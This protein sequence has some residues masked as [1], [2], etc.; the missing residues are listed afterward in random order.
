[1][2]RIDT[3]AHF[4]PSFYRQALM[5]AGITQP[6]GMPAIPEWDE[7]A[8]L[9][10]LE[11]LEIQAVV[12]SI[13]SPGVYFG[14]AAA[15]RALARRCNTEGHRLRRAHPGRFG[16]FATT[17]LPDV[18]G[19]L[20][21][22][23]YAL[24]TLGAEGVAIETNSEGMYGDD[25]RL[26]PFYAELDRRGA[27]LFIHPTSPA[28]NAHLPGN[29]HLPAPMLEFM[30][31]TTRN[32][33][34]IILSGV[35]VRHPR[36]RFLIPHAGA[37]LPALASRIHA[38][39]PLILP[40]LTGKSAESYPD[41][42]AELHKIYFDLAGAPL[43]E[44]LPALL[45]LADHTRIFYGSDWPFTPLEACRKLARQL[46]ETP[47]LDPELKRAVLLSN[48]LRMFPSLNRG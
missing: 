26:E 5:A 1:M 40:K 41:I 6:D 21:E 33:T 38:Q 10:H 39:G 14:D 43:P 36:I 19:A 13:S 12:L 20:D 31:E 18:Q 37:A 23:R 24:D 25:P 34:A 30:F 44:L 2:Q 22:L 48:A 11:A 46:D 35:T 28:C 42:R 9:R 32:L 16:F 47:L 4:L 17:P 3:H 15:A 45:S 7:E 27:V 29:P 8:A